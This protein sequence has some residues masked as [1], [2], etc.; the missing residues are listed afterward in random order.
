MVA[1]GMTDEAGATATDAADHSAAWAPG[2]IWR[3]IARGGLAGILV[4]IVVAGIGGR[5]VM[6]LAALLVPVAN[7]AITENDNVIGEITLRGTLA[8]VIFIG[9][10]FGASA[11]TIWVV[12]RPWLPGVGVIRALWAA[13]VAI[14]LGTFSLIRGG[15]SDF[16]VLGYDPVIVGSLV[17]L[18]GLMGIGLSVVDGW[19][20]RRLP[21]PTS[22]RS[23]STS[24]YAAITLVGGLLILPLVVG[25]FLGGEL[26]WVGVGLIVVGVATLRWWLLRL[27][28]ADRPPR[29]LLLFGRASLAV[30][31]LLGLLI[32]LP[33]LRGALGIY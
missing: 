25:S 7:G 10:F 33:E 12:V 2:L 5:L 22:A 31:V 23:R 27:R 28:G 4:G 11:G 15:N 3:D 14:G 29:S 13:V 20:D 32:E 24:V 16:V 6:R 9:L 26:R 8:L 19:L 18:V 30:T 17:A 21:V 1:T